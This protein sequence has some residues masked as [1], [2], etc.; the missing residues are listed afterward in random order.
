MLHF[1]AFIIT[2]IILFYFAYI[3]LKYPFWSS[4]PVYHNYDVLRSMYNN[5]FIINKHTPMKTKYYDPLQVKTYTYS[6]CENIHKNDILS[7]Q[8]L[9]VPIKLELNGYETEVVRDNI[10]LFSEF[11]FEVEL[12]LLLQLSSKSSNISPINNEANHF[13]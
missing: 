9:L 13:I 11:G 3:K 2:F 6:E 1:I 10:E 4:Q 5:P 7:I 8:N 12:S